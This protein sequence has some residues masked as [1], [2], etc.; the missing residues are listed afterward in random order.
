[1]SKDEL[2]AK[3]QIQ[4]EEQKEKINNLE[5]V[6]KRIHSHIYCCSGPLN[7]NLLGYSGTQMVTFEEIAK[8]LISV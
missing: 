8:E 1:M 7:G 5:E 3:Q 2:I 6:E 4:I